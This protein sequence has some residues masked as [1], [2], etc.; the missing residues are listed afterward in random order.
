MLAG[1]GERAAPPLP[2]ATPALWQVADDDTRIVLLGAVHALPGDLDWLTGRVADLAESA[3]ELVL[4]ISPNEPPDQAGRAFA[5]L[6][7][8]PPAPILARVPATLR[9][10]L[11]ELA[12]QADQPIVALDHMD[13]WAV[14]VLLSSAAAGRA[15]I[16]RANGV[17]A[18]LTERFRSTGRPVGGLES[19]AGQFGLLDA[20]PAAS[21]R[22]YLLRVLRAEA[23]GR[24]P[25]PRAIAAWRRGDADALGRLV[26]AELADNPPLRQALV[27]RRNRAWA[28]W[29]QRRLDRPGVVLMA[30]GAGHLA[31][32]DSLQ[33]MLAA[34]GL[35]V[36]RVQ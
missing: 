19:S 15:G 6:A 26:N 28:D 25:L 17:E 5:T 8:R 11:G 10:E 30:V 21:Q 29:V 22:A 12:R 16:T 20:L 13:D 36:R 4:E 2:A 27:T 9:D 32:A 1:C 34:K 31:G 23:E 24:D 7:V 14:A 33:V 3:D 35:T 18:R